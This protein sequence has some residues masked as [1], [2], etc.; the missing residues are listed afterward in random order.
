MKMRI[1]GNSLRLRLSIPE[2]DVLADQKMVSDKI[3]FGEH[4]LVY[5]VQF[6]DTT[7]IMA[8]YSGAQ[9]KV[10]VPEKAGLQWATSEQVGMESGEEEGSPSILIEK[11]FACLKPRAG[12]DES[13][14]YPNP[15]AE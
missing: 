3:C 6:T 5:S 10:L 14:L 4:D 12:E 13:L 2:V 11:D 7:R 8:S 15:Q 9:I 1:L